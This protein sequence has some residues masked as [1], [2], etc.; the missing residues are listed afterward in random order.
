MLN[1]QNVIS[2]SITL[3]GVCMTVNFFFW[4]GYAA[5]REDPG[6]DGEL[7]LESIFIDGYNVLYLFGPKGVEDVEKELWKI[8]DEG[9]DV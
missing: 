4:H 2:R 1:S 5:T 6:F 3:K 9:E 8:L 7:E